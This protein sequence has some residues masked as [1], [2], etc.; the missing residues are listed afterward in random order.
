[1]MSKKNTHTKHFHTKPQKTTALPHISNLPLTVS[2]SHLADE[3][4][5]AVEGGDERVHEQGQVGEK[6]AEPHGDRQT[7]LHE[8]VLHVLAVQAA[9][10]AVQT[11]GSDKPH[12]VSE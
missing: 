10:Q 3:C 9:L 2:I 7:Q 4:L 1:M 12:A 5:G 8:Q 11:W 6:G